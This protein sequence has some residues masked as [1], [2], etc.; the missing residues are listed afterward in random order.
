MKMRKPLLPRSESFYKAN[1]H[2]H[3]TISD[4]KLTPEA[5]KEHYKSGG[6]SI[7][8]YTDHDVMI[9]HHDLTDESF[10]ALTGF[11][12]EV[13]QNDCY[14]LTKDIS[15]C[16]ICFIAGSPDTVVQPCWNSKY[17]EIGNAKKYADSV[18]YDNEKPPFERHYT[19]E[20]INEIMK[21][22]RDAG[23]FVTYNHP[24]WSLESYPVY[25]AYHGMHAMELINGEC[26]F[27]G[28]ND[29]NAQKYDDVLRNGER[30]FAVGADDNHNSDNFSFGGFVMI[31]A[32][33]LEYK[34]ITDAL[35][36]GD[37]YASGGPTINELYFEDGK[38]FISTSDAVTITVNT[39]HRRAWSVRSKDGSLINSASFQI[40]DGDG[41]VRFTVRDAAGKE[42][43][44]R[45]F[46]LDELV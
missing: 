41:Y 33:K 45:A 39:S 8:A 23:F 18:V 7:I 30:I 24:S 5:M 42:A 13:N 4:G 35:V 43:Y 25:T 17:A 16:H 29:N 12:V 27:H 10:L 21:T 20:C 36:R 26:N 46:F 6:Y 14:P 9:P 40:H 28:Y 3:S 44:T 2:S 1:L 15:T 31:K 37:F 38:V 32:K 34:E 19:P 11:E 22:C